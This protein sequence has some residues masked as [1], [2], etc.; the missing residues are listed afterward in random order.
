MLFKLLVVHFAIC[1]LINVI[2]CDSDVPQLTDDDFETIISQYE[3]SL[4]MFYA[5][6]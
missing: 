2:A 1:S 3:T 4:V 6:W 5:P